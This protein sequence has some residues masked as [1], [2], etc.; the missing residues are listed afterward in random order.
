MV[1]GI[2]DKSKIV[3]IIVVFI[4]ILIMDKDYKIYVIYIVRFMNKFINEK[5]KFFIGSIIML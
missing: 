2:N 3:N 5:V 1:R 4:S